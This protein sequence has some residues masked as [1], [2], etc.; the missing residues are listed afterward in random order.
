M[1]LSCLVCSTVGC[2]SAEFLV[3]RAWMPVCQ[4]NCKNGKGSR[5]SADGTKYDGNWRAGKKHGK[6]VYTWPDGVSYAG[7]WREGKMDGKGVYT[8]GDGH[9]FDGKWTDGTRQEGVLSR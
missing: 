9:K 7:D 6:G 1:R 3:E 8:W 2:L 5:T 4:G